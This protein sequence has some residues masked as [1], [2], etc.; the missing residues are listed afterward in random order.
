[1]IRLKR[2]FRDTRLIITTRRDKSHRVRAVFVSISTH[3]L[4][5]Q[6]F[7]VQIAIFLDFFAT[8]YW[9]ITSIEYEVNKGLADFVSTDGG[10]IHFF[11]LSGPG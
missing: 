2:K 8:F 1:M 9:I 5:L 6:S 10:A 11:L 4:F 7:L 3:Y